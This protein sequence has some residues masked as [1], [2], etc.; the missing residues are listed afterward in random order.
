MN[1]SLNVVFFCSK[2][3]QRNKQIAMGRKKFN[4]DPKKVPCS[5]ATK[6]TSAYNQPL[7]RSLFQMLSFSITHPLSSFSS[8]GNPVPAGERPPSTNSR[9]HCPI[10][11]QRRGPQQ[12]RHRRLLRRTV[13]WWGAK[14]NPFLHEINVP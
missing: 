14:E 10:P 13:R 6:N 11:L 3:S 7:Y 4:M 9:R 12:D 8:S 2:T 1:K 5:F